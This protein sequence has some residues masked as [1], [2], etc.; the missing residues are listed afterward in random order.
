MNKCEVCDGVYENN[1]TII[2][3]EKNH[4]FDCLE[5]AIKVLAPRC[6]RCGSQILGHIHTKQKKVYCGSLCAWNSNIMPLSDRQSII[7]YL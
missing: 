5:C 7:H 1:F 2:I 4:E 3:G 6:S